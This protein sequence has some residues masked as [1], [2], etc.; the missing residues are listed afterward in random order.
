[1]S[2]IQEEVKTDVLVIGGAM[3]YPFLKAQGYE[4]GTSLCSDE[5]VEL[6]KRIL[7][8]DQLKKIELPIDHNASKEFGG[9]PSQ[10]SECNIPTDMMGLDIGEHGNEAYP[11]FQL[12]IT[13]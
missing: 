4:V 1:M 6:A 11:G 10:I 7:K 12:F 5:D 2:Y 13:Q 9:T 3:A 8:S